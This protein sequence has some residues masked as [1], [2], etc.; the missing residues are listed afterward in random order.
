MIGI[1]F[2]EK[3]HDRNKYDFSIEYTMTRSGFEDLNWWG[4]GLN[5]LLRKNICRKVVRV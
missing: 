3:G 1:Y 2:L 5:K 4:G